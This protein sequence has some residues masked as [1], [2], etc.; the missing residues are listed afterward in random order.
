MTA[1]YQPP[2]PERHPFESASPSRSAAGALRVVL[3]ED[4][5]PVAGAMQALLESAGFE[6]AW[7]AS[8]SAARR[9]V[10]STRPDV[11]LV[12]IGLPDTSGVALIRWLV[13][14][15]RCG[16][17]VLSGMAD[18]SDRVLSLELGADD[19]VLKPP[20]PRE[21]IARIHAVRR[22][23]DAASRPAAPA[24]T[25]HRFEVG[26][27]HVDLETGIVVGADGQSIDLT[28]AE[29]ALLA[30]L[31]GANGQPVTR[32]QLSRDVLHRPWRVEDRSIDQL[33][34]QLRQKLAP[35]GDGLRLVQAVRGA[36]YL[37]RHTVPD[38][39]HKT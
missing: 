32:D 13:E 29:F 18:E 24:P 7:A 4:E 10:A 1:R 35:D 9:L 33:V 20:A 37:M 11:V 16:I 2:D 22:R 31:I 12:D 36:G 3:V 23:T 5:E 21:L 34:F 8:G 19:Y 28:T 17:I 15:E 26:G 25:P 39:A 30:R 27:V 38:L 6:V 14:N